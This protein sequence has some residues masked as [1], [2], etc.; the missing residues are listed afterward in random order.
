M[1]D[2]YDGKYQKLSVRLW[3]YLFFFNKRV[4]VL[5]STFRK[6]ITAIRNLQK[7]V[8]RTIGIF[9]N[10]TQGGLLIHLN[11][12]KV[13]NFT[14]KVIQCNAFVGCKYTQKY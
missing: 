14:N 12:G 4:D 8:S 5:L 11:G 6:N 2:P 3:K 7:P 9:V 1:E 13:E 10:D